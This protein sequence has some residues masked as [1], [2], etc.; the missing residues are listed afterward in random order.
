[1]EAEQVFYNKVYYSDSRNMGEIPSNS[2]QLIVTS[3]PYFNI[4]DYS[5]DGY[6]QVQNGEKMNGQI[7]D[8]D[9]YEKYIQELLI[10]WKECYRVLK[11]NGKLA[12]NTPLMPILKKNLNTHYNRHIFD[13]DS[14]IK[15]SILKNTKLF[16]LDV[17]IWNRANPSKK[18]MFG[19][20]PYSRNFY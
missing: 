3:P 5:L 4:K 9:D 18:V 7:G 20:Y 16:L 6:Q 12:I 1:M 14:D 2:I 19:S 8:I 11:P 17:F 13:I 10:V 15:N